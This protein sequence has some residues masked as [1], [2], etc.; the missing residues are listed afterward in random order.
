[1]G[2]LLQF[3]DEHST[4]VAMVRKFASNF[5]IPKLHVVFDE[6]F[7]TIQ[8]DNR[9]EETA[10][11]TTFNSLFTNFRGFMVKR[12]AL[13]RRVYQLHRELLRNPPRFRW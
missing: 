10:G 3:S 12:D 8:T 9:L 11:E 6:K 13:P 5:L 7:S 4:L 1:M 2:K